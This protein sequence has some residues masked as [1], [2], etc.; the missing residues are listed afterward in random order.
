MPQNKSTHIPIL[1]ISR[2]VDKNPVSIKLF[3]GQLPQLR[4]IAAV[5][6]TDVASLMRDAIDMAIQAHERGMVR[7]PVTEKA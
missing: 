1:T 2:R 4:E 7:R 3:E 5:E 6:K